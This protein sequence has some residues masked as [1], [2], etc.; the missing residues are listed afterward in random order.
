MRVIGID[1]GIERTGFAILEKKGQGFVLH[2]CGC[3][4]TQRGLPL[5]ARLM[6]LADDL[7]TLVRQWQPIGAGIEKVYFS[8]NVKTAMT[9]SHARGVILETLEEHGIPLQEFNPADIK[10]AVTGYGGADKEQMKKMVQILLGVSLKNDDTADAIACGM[11]LL[12]TH[13]FSDS[14]A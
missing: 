1:P 11:C 14:F 10:I 13:T 9:V 3:I 2:D 7:R 4:T 5:S 12:S 6:T 8:K